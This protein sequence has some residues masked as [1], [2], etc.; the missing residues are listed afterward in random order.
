MP[1]PSAAERQQVLATVATA[2]RR[3]LEAVWSKLNHGKPADL[4]PT[5]AE[6]LA[7]IA[8]R[9]GAAAASLAAD[10]YDQARLDAGAP[11][12]FTAQLAPA[13]S[14]DRLDVLARWGIGPLFG[15]DPS[16]VAALS[17]LAGGMQRLVLDQAR[18]TTASS[19]A[20]DPA[21]PRYARHASA[22][23]C[24]FCALLASRGP[25]YHSEASALTVGGRGTDVATNVGRTRGRKAQGVKPR[26][27]QA[28]GDRYHDDCHCTAVE[29][30]PGQH[31]DAAPYVA[32]WDAAYVRATKAT[33]K[34]GEAIDLSKVLAHMRQDL[35]LA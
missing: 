13:P 1:A 11:G 16:P 17:L 31:Y 27:T 33:A 19:V 35:G 25:V 12:R 15:A 14:Q 30:F 24:A 26:G 3:E 18:D 23:A 20:A 29:V 9:Y 21:K 32:E 28:L 34:S 2:A 10:W 5:L 22:N 8:D 4:A 7:A 6:V